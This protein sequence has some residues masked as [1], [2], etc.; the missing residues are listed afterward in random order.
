MNLEKVREALREQQDDND[1]PDGYPITPSKPVTYQKVL[2]AAATHIS[3]TG[4]FLQADTPITE[5]LGRPNPTE[6]LCV[7]D[8]WAI[9]SRARSSNAI[10][11]DIDG[12]I[13]HVRKLQQTQ[14]PLPESALRFVR[15]GEESGPTFDALAAS[16]AAAAEQPPVLF[17]VQRSTG[18]DC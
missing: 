12:M 13:N 4:H 5:S 17:P 1:K 9:F 6:R 8:T 7:A 16:A 11:R 18:A 2:Q 14:S 10:V 3:S 15:F